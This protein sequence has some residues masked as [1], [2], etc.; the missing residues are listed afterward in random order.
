MK[1]KFLHLTL[2]L[3]SIG[4][5]VGCTNTSDLE[6]TNDFEQVREVAWTFVVEQGWNDRAEEDWQ[7]AEVKKAIAR[8]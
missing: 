5:I 8:E 6:N 1:L 3:V 7:S 2:T 4:L